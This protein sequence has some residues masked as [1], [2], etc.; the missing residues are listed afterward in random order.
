MRFIYSPYSI[1]MAWEEHENCI[2]QIENKKVYVD[3]LSD[4]YSQIYHGEGEAILSD[5]EKCIDIKKST[6]VILEPFSIDFNNRK[7]K[8]KV[9][10]ELSTIALQNH[11][12]QYND[13]CSQLQEFMEKLLIEVPYSIAYQSSIVVDELF[14]AE[15]VELDYKYESLA[16][17]I[18]I[19]I[20]LLSSACGVRAVFFNDM[21][22]F[23]SDEE[24]ISVFKEAQYDKVSIIDISTQ[25]KNRYMAEGIVHYILDETLCFW[26]V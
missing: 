26:K 25:D 12:L 3:L 5:G 13:I 22:R 9:Y 18:C 14:K 16:E 1:D 19:Y 6:E 8:G 4:L 7:I 20:K 17:K 2:L 24:M 10:Q 11:F 15:A 21:G 23:L